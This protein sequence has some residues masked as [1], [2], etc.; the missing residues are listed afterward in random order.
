VTNYSLQEKYQILSAYLQGG[1][2]EALME[3]H[4]EDESVIVHDGKKYKRIQIEGDTNDYLMDED[5]NI[6][7]SQMEFVGEAGGTESEGEEGAG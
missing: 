7:N 3:D 2:V 4:P 5:G 6:Y 1:G